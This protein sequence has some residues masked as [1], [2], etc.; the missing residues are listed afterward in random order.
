MSVANNTGSQTTSAK[1]GNGGRSEKES[2]KN[3]QQSANPTKNITLMV[4]VSLFVGMICQVPFSVCF[5]LSWLGM[6]TPLFNEVYTASVYFVLS[7]PCLDIFIYY[8]FNKLFKSVV[9]A[10]I[11][12][13]FRIKK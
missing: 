1:T 9:D 10:A 6:N 8:F 5:I 7:A 4:I 13:L 11:K 3:G 2:K 12:K